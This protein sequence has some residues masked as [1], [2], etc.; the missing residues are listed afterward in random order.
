VA[1]H[2]CVKPEYFRSE[3]L[4]AVRAEL[5]SALLPDGRLGIFHPDNFTFGQPVH[6]SAIV[7][8]AQSVEGVESVRLDKFQRLVEP[9]PST[10]E[11][12]VIPIGRLEIAQLANNPNYRDRGRLALSGGGGK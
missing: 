3:V 1:L 11:N 12:G 10:Q 9:D 2:V 8:A 4:R 6:S 5:S 7:A